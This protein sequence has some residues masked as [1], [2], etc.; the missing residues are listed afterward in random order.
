MIEPHPREFPAGV[1]CGAGCSNTEG[2]R[3]EYRDDKGE[4]CGWFC[5]N[6]TVFV[7]GQPSCRRHAATVKWVEPKEGAAYAVGPLGG[8]G[9]RSPNLVGFIVDLLDVE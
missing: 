5:R 1:R 7:H 9:D 3:C 6:H 2:Y 8:V 4:Q